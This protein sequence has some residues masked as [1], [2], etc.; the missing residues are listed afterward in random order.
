MTEVFTPPNIDDSIIKETDKLPENENIS[1]T[2]L[3][4]SVF[5]EVDKTTQNTW[6]TI[7][8]LQL[9]YENAGK[10]L[11]IDAK[12]MISTTSATDGYSL[13][14]NSDL[15]TPV[16]FSVYLPTRYSSDAEYVDVEH[17]LSEGDSETYKS[18]KVE[19]NDEGL[20]YIEI[21]VAEFSKF[22][23]TA[24][25]DENTNTGDTNTGDTNV[26][27]TNTGTVVETG[28]NTNIM[29]FIIMGCLALVG[30][31]FVGFRRKIK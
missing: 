8:V 17:V 13:I 11:V 10:T 21:T 7:D 15:K 28:D 23:I 1:H 29:L 14:Q 26:G 18:L 3:A 25:Q 9:P 4:L 19:T 22:K 30:M 16:T 31:G 12:P 20:R 24:Q 27:G 5:G 2:G 6:T